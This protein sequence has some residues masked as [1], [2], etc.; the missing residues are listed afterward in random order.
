[1]SLEWMPRS[2]TEQDVKNSNGELIKFNTTFYISF[3]TYQLSLK[4]ASKFLRS[5]LAKY[6]KVG[7]A[8]NTNNQYIS[9]IVKALNVFLIKVAINLLMMTAYKMYKI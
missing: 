2:K 5:S 7:A 8:E 4:Y 6:I 9:I 3:V 1:M